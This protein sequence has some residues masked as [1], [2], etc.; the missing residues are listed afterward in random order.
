ME[1]SIPLLDN[2]PD[3]I[4][5]LW[6]HEY[7]YKYGCSRFTKDINGNDIIEEQSTT[8]SISIHIQISQE[9]Y[10]LPNEY[11]VNINDCSLGEAKPDINTCLKTTDGVDKE[12]KEYEAKEISSF[13][14]QRTCQLVCHQPYLINNETC[15]NDERDHICHHGPYN[16]F[17]KMKY[18]MP[19][20]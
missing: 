12:T 3:D 6:N 11:Y 4:E 17:M 10:R 8:E 2:Q 5:Q 19:K 20:N 14:V 1:L 16:M 7:S 13:N 18:L 9:P 15:N